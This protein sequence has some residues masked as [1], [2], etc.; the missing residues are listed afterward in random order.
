MRNFLMATAA[1]A[2]TAGTAIA[3]SHSDEIK[4]VGR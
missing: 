1:A 2:L 4:I 3:G